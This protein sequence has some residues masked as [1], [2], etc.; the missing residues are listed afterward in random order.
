V[1][2]EELKRKAEG[3][4]YDR[5]V[6]DS[7]HGLLLTHLEKWAAAKR[8]PVDLEV[9][10]LLLELRANYDDL[11]PTYWP[12]DSVADLLL[13]LVPA[14]GPQ[15]PMEPDIVVSTLDS[16]FRFLRNT[17]RMAP[18]SASP[19]E[20]VKEARRSARQMESAVSDRANWSPGKVL[21]DFGSQLGISLDDGADTD[22]IQARLDAIQNAWNDLP[23]HERQ[24]RMP[25][26]T[27]R[28]DESGSDRAMSA[29][30]TGNEIDA[31]ILGFRY[32]LPTGQLPVPAETAPIVREAGLLAM[33]EKLSSWV[34]PKTE[35][36]AT[37]VL[38]PAEA[39]RAYA[40][41]GL[42]SWARERARISLA[43]YTPP[44]IEEIGFEEF[45]DK[46]ADER[47][48]SARDCQALDR[49][50]VAAIG[51]GAIR[52][53]GKY[54]YPAWPDG[55]DDESWLG[56]GLR[57]AI[58]VVEDFLYLPGRGVAI[59]YAWLRSY[60]RKRAVVPW[61]EMLDF[62]I[63]WKYAPAA[64]ERF[65]EYGLM[66]RE[67]EHKV[68]RSAVY[69]LKD[70][71]IFIA[72]DAGLALTPFGDVFVSTWLNYRSDVSG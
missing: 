29:F 17:G 4:S 21:L 69:S 20:L 35:I 34:A 56:H 61:D 65:A 25:K 32:E 8:R 52:T 9:L 40:D 50:W 42:R 62:T 15:E 60:V 30:G 54:V 16:Y 37:T 22:T 14:K 18:R 55:L 70:T 63:D 26:P 19:A 5:P 24:R 33:V 2:A 10:D 44:R 49:L 12:S 28:R 58:A 71:G 51:C 53:R 48:R 67:V 36:T 64:R 72:S 45:L 27:D 1:S 7:P 66:D 23:I 46:I 47:W 3:I 38:R 31:L 57:A 43:D 68:L 13:R 39:H 6:T 59:V 41:L 11:E